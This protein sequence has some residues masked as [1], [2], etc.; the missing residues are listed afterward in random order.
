MNETEGSPFYIYK[1]VVALVQPRINYIIL[2][3]VK[4]LTGGFTFF[5]RIMKT[6][7]FTAQN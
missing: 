7:R 4:S 3:A 5:P 6:A 1:K 2:G